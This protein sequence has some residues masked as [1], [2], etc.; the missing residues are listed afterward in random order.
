MIEITEKE[1]EQLF[2]ERIR[3]CRDILIV[4][5]KEYS[6]DLDKMRNFNVAGRMLGMA[7]YKVAFYYMMKH[8]ESFYEIVIEDREVSRELW[9]EKVGDLLNYIFLID[10]MVVKAL[11][12]NTQVEGR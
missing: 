5:A 11:F 12:H 7:P 3:K 9:D 8:F 4:K 1:F 2:E 6:T 10:A